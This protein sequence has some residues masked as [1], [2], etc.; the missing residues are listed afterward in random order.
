MAIDSK[1]S[2]NPYTIRTIFSK[3][4]YNIV[5]FL[6][7]HW[8]ENHIFV[9]NK[10]LLDWQHLSRDSYNFVG[11]FEKGTGQLHGILGFISPSFYVN[12]TIKT[13]EDLWLAIWKVDKS[14][15]RINSLGLDLLEYIKHNYHPRSISAIGINRTVEGLYKLLG[16][17]TGVLC[18]MFVM[19]PFVETFLIATVKESEEGSRFE[20]CNDVR[21]R[22][23]ERKLLDGYRILFKT[24][25]HNKSL[26]YV[27]ARYFAHPIYKYH[28]CVAEYLVENDIVPI[29]LFVFRRINI[30]NSSC[31]RI[32]DAFGL[33]GISCSLRA[34]LERFLSEQNAEYIDIMCDG[35][36]V[37]LLKKAGFIL[38]TATNYVPHYF[39]PFDPAQQIVRFATSSKEKYDI[40]KGDSD[41]DRPNI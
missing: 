1:S 25:P 37:P 15:A 24:T 29:C 13:N 28:I 3:E 21:I 39:E 9:Q 12:R 10:D 40:F 36:H 30:N 35:Y 33:Q 19:N 27:A 20:S 11:A 16:Y 4:Y 38:N 2:D 26:E 31:L 17:R 41:L 34:A 32:V 8:S 7:K 5:D 18:Q 23:I 14:N 6:K 22:L